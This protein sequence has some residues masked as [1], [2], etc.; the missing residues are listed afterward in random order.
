VCGKHQGCVYNVVPVDINGGLATFTRL[1]VVLC[2][3]EML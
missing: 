1:D 3:G 2:T